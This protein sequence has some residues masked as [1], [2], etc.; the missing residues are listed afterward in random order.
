LLN[1]LSIVCLGL[2]PVPGLGPLFPI[3]SLPFFK[4]FLKT[5]ILSHL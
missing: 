4:F 3:F 5:L 1:F 2:P